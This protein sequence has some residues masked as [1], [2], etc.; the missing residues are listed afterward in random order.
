MAAVQL[1]LFLAGAFIRESS[2]APALPAEVP[3]HADKPRQHILQPRGLDLQAGFSG[4]GTQSEDLQDDTG[5]VQYLRIK[6]FLKVTHL[7]RRQRF[8]KDD[9]IRAA[10]FDGQQNFVYLAAADQCRAGYIRR[11]LHDGS[12]GLY[13]AGFCQLGKLMHRALITLRTAACIDS[14]ENGAGKFLRLLQF[15]HRYLRFHKSITNERIKHCTS[16]NQHRMIFCRSSRF[17]RMR[18]RL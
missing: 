3:A 11:I 18:V 1:E 9:K 14:D 15:D 2:G 4:A 6:S 13:T 12:G 8:I 16:E 17:T 5:F 7:H 10:L